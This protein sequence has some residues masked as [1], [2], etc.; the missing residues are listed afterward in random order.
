MIRVY[1]PP[2]TE[3]PQRGQLHPMEAACR[4]YAGGGSIPDPN[5]AAADGMRADALN[6]PKN[7]LVNAAAEMG[8]K[9]TVG[10]KTYD[11]TGLGNA[12][13]SNIIS[14]QMAQTM[15]DIQK[16]YAPQFIQQKLDEL[17]QSDPNGYAARKQLFD[18]IINDSKTNPNRPLAQDLQDQVQTMLQGAGKLDDNALQQVQQGVRGGQ[19]AKGIYLGNAPA[20]QEASAVVGASDNL[21][22]QQQQQAE[23][24][25]ASGISPQDVEYRRIQQS[26]ANL[27]AAINGQTPEAQFTSVSGAGNGAAPFQTPNYSTPASLN[28]NAAEIGV[29]FANQ[30]Y[31]TSQQN[32]NPW[33]AGLSTVTNAANTISNL[34]PSSTAQQSQSFNFAASTPAG[35]ANTAAGIQGI[36]NIQQGALY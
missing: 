3:T 2:A 10:N 25:L 35:Q 18:R 15:L 29:G 7:W 8:N 17:K 23:G 14:D 19:V 30:N 34:W 21:R 12:D 4:C 20:S 27:G 1:H 16:N 26:L 6:F 22:S 31:Q 32:A 9:I 28:P 13:Q 24:Y 33:L 5:L 11:F 36:N